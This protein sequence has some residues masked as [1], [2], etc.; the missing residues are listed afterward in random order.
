MLTLSDRIEA[1]RNSTACLWPE[2]D[3]PAAI[4]RA[5][6]PL[7]RAVALADSAAV[8]VLIQAGA[9]VNAATWFG[10]T[11]LHLCV[12]RY[13]IRRRGY[14]TTA[15]DETVLA[16]LL[17]AG[18]NVRARDFH[19]EMPAAWA[20]GFMPPALKAAMISC[21]N[22]GAWP[23]DDRQHVVEDGVHTVKAVRRGPAPHH[24]GPRWLQEKRRAA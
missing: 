10:L 8:R 13:A 9:D 1:T 15:D 16:L 23:E 12:R 6:T 5:P 19:G 7:H 11:P 14:T 3:R 18:A 22:A 24:R 2:D 4:G 21:A 20:E 17:A